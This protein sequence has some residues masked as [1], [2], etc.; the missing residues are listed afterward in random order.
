MRSTVGSG[1]PSRLRRLPALVAQ[2]LSREKGLAWAYSIVEKVTMAAG[3]SPSS[4][5]TSP[6]AQSVEPDVKTSP[7]PALV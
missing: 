3:A 4:R 7:P 5:P 2:E 1:S 6:C